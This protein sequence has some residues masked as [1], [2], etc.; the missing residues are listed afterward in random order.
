[1]YPQLHDQVSRLLQ[2]DDLFFDFRTTDSGEDAM[3]THDT[4]V[5]GRFVCRNKACVKDSWSSKKI[6]V[7]IRMYPGAQYNVRVYHQRCNSCEA[8]SRPYLDNS[9]ADRTA[10]RIKKW[11]GVQTET[12]HHVAKKSKGPHDSERC[13]GCK[14]G[15][16]SKMLDE[17]E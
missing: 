9:Y 6:P 10:Y 11:C 15:H 7:T 16:C 8:L 14:D 2:E 4:N 12:P 17:F 1:M 3:Q 13:E 5:M